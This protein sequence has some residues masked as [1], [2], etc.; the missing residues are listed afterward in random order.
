MPEQDQA[1]IDEI[2]LKSDSLTFSLPEHDNLKAKNSSSLP[3]T[4]EKEAFSDSET[5]ENSISPELSRVRKSINSEPII[6]K[7]SDKAEKPEVKASETPKKVESKTQKTLF[8]F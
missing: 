3:E 8:D 5:T 6:K 2:E 4:F 1:G 7:V